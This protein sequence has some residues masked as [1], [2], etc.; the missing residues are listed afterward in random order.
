MAPRLH[1]GR[2]LPALLCISSAL[3]CA[4]VRP[5]SQREATLDGGSQESRPLAQESA[6]AQP[7]S[8]QTVPLWRDGKPAGEVDLARPHDARIVVLDLGEDWTPYIFT[9]RSSPDDPP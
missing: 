9:E 2:W 6:P 8:S 7:R 4:G 3:A 1:P 5:P